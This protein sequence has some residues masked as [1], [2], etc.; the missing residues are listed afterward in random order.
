[1]SGLAPLQG[2]SDGTSY[3]KEAWV[4]VEIQDCERSNDWETFTERL[5]CDET[6]TKEGPHVS[7][8]AYKCEAI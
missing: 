5:A 3:G 8:V 6:I 4:A 2:N 1:M 7:Q